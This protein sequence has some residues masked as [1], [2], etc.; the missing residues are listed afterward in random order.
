MSTS[1]GLR[2]VAP[3]TPSADDAQPAVGRAVP[4]IDGPLKVSG[5]AR[6]TSDVALPDMLQA[7][8][9]CATIGAGSVL[10]ID[11]AAAR[12]M[13]GVR[14]VFTRFNIG[15]LQRVE[16]GAT[17]DEKRPPFEDDLV[18]YYGQYV[19][20]V[21]A[22][23]FEQATAAARC[24]DVTYNAEAPD[25]SEVTGPEGSP[26]V[27]SE[28]GDVAHGLQEADVTV[29]QAYRTPPE[30]HNPIELH[31]TLASFDGSTYTVYETSQGVVNARA[32]IAQMLDVAVDDVRVITEY[33]GSGFGSKL[34][35]WS[36]TL[37]ACAAS[38]QLGV[39]VRLV[40]DRRTMFAAVGHRPGTLQRMRIGATRDGKLTALQQD[41]IND[42]ARDGKYKEDC[43]E[44]TT[45]LYSTPNLRVTSA[46]AR[47]DIGVC[48]SMRGPGAVPGLWAVESAMDEL[49][50]ALAIDPVDLRLRNEPKTDEGRNVPFSSR[51]LDECLT[52]G[53]HAF[54]WSQRDP[55]PGSMRRDGLVLGWGM[56][57]CSWLAMR[58][59]AKVE[60]RL[61]ADGSVRVASAAQDIGTGTY[62]VV[63]QMVADLAGVPM[64]RV[65]VVLGD[66]ALPPGP[67]SGGSM[68]TASMV[69]ALMVAAQDAFDALRGVAA[70]QSGVEMET[71]QVTAGRL[72]DVGEPAS[73]GRSFPEVLQAAGIDHVDGH[74]ASGPSKLDEGAADV[75]IHS[76]GA[77]FVEVTWQPE[78]ARLRVS[79]VVTVIDA[80]RILNPR[81][82]RNQ[83]EGAIMM[84]VGM[85]L[86]EATEYDE[87]TGAPINA[88]LADYVVTTHA[89]APAVDI[90]FLDY[91]DTALN[92]LGARGIGEIGIAG[93]APAIAAA[94]HHATGI[95]V[96]SLPIRIED[97]LAD[98]AID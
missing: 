32:V 94:V 55:R 17:L 39:P 34:W 9:V 41:F 81:M 89:D 20:L 7:V 77:H 30:T 37:L 27:D 21:V 57:A 46:L 74:G 71:L 82:G 6:Y 8:P 50:I 58:L 36:H 59:P 83:I 62:T 70:R 73:S 90:H 28:R 33:L 2:A 16:K 18:R 44:A 13:P 54:G 40:I 12:A 45:Y 23:T 88:N 15:P 42:C 1:S 76:Y 61:R 52:K 47:R 14:E 95:R 78:L 60:L 43:G 53:A 4:R 80:G 65:E 91:P 64:D 93:I 98:A 79:R 92:P 69:P 24:V 84:G 48:T 97:L 19:A 66:T 68:L 51:H 63:A 31:A 29:D 86:F 3:A 75:S 38:R 25:V 5:Q 56:A 72:H 49:A 96:R 85:A 67:L 11:A 22:D 35:P 87:H 10:A 26:E